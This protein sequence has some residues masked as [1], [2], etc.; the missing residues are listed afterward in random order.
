M[1]RVR[2]FGGTPSVFAIAELTFLVEWD[3][4]MCFGYTHTVSGLL[5]FIQGVF[6][7]KAKSHI[8]LPGQD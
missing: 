3:I 1:Y 4:K 2:F 7:S 5:R 6:G 8:A